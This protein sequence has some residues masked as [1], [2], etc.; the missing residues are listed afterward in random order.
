[1]AVNRRNTNLS[2]GL[3]NALQTANPEYIFA[4]RAPTSADTAAFGTFWFYKVSSTSVNMYIFTS[5][6]SWVQIP[7]GSQSPIFSGLT[8]NGATALNGALTVNSGTSAIAIGTDAFA[9]TITLGN[10]TGATSIALNAGTAGISIGTNAI[11]HTVTLGNVTGASAVNVN[12]G[13]GGSTVTTTNGIFTVATGTGTVTISGD[14]TANTVLVGSGAGVK[15]VTVGSTN[16][17]SATI[18]QAGSGKVTITSPTAALFSSSIA[19]APVDSNVATAAFTASL[20][21][22]TSVQ[23]TTGYDLLVNITLIV[24]S[25]TTATI[26]LGVG[27]ATGPTT[28]TVVPSF[29]TAS[30][31]IIP[32]VAWV[33]NNYF[34]V[35]NTTGTITV[36]SATVQ[37][38]AL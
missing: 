6:S 2:Y 12:T 11:A 17:T 29:S 38:C 13:T 25:S 21:A 4:L 31:I 26:V 28:N 27:S 23:N 18:I 37:S 9:K 7:L 15:A 20:T 1:M 10:S 32:I 16:T 3:N 35:Y 24:S 14:A 34:L 33:P 30:S 8:V 36:A 5:A 19:T 22:G